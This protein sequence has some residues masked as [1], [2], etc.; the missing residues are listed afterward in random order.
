M[1]LTLLPA[2]TCRD[3]YSILATWVVRFSEGF[4]QSPDFLC[5]KQLMAYVTLHMPGSDLEHRARRLLARPSPGELS[6]P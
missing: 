6:T 4:Q 1:P 2:P 3:M 5:L